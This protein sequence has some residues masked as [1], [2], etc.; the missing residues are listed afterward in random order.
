MPA[1]SGRRPGPQ[2]RTT[3]EN[4]DSLAWRMSA[5]P[6]RLFH[7]PTA[8]IAGPGAHVMQHAL[9]NLAAQRNRALAMV[10]AEWVLFVDADER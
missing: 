9:E 6:G 2:R 3:S 1:G 4:V 7:R 8:E 10:G 5:G